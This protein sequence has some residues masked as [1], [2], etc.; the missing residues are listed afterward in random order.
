VAVPNRR[1]TV[2]VIRL[3]PRLQPKNNN[4]S[5]VDSDP[6]SSDFEH[7]IGDDDYS[8][9]SVIDNDLDSLDW[10][11]SYNGDD[12][13]WEAQGNL[14]WEN[15]TSYVVKTT[16]GAQLHPAEVHDRKASR[17]SDV[18]EEV[19]EQPPRLPP[20]PPPSPGEV[21]TTPSTP[22]PPP[23]LL[24]PSPPPPFVPPLH[25]AGFSSSDD[26]DDTFQVSSYQ[27]SLTPSSQAVS[28][29]TSTDTIPY[30]DD[31]ASARTS[32]AGSRDSTPTPPDGLDAHEEAPHDDYQYSYS[33]GR[34]NTAAARARGASY[35]NVDIVRYTIGTAAAQK[36]VDEGGEEEQSRKNRTSAYENVDEVRDTLK[37]G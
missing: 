33:A 6:F 17:E 14:H 35:E 21:K 20:F 24:P 28:H 5:S 8:G 18:V 15:N 1:Q 36:S 30:I 2:Q 4:A 26:D 16:N 37:V 34:R 23:P 12:V 29:V 10:E 9:G 27:S 11:Q 13:V 19:F 7:L 25:E 3:S 31:T 22:S 32:S